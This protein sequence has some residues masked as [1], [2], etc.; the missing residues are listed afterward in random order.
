MSFII[1]QLPSDIIKNIQNQLNFID[2]CNLRLVS[3]YFTICPIT[4]LFDDVPNVHK[5]SDEI[6]KLYPF[7]I[8]LY[9]GNNANITDINHLIDLQILNAWGNCGI[10]DIGLRKLTNLTKLNAGDNERIT[11]INH[12]AKLQILYAPD[13]CGIDDKGLCQLTNLIELHTWNNK[14]ITNI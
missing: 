14:K 13:D 2:Q 7:C 10:D 1:D 12:L 5:L 9:A 11:N 6:L 3:T 4:N 8:K